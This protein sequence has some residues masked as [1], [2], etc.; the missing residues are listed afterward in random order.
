MLPLS[1]EALVSL[2]I[3][4]RLFSQ[5]KSLLWS[6]ESILFVMGF[7][8]TLISLPKLSFPRNKQCRI[9]KSEKEGKEEKCKR[10]LGTDRVQLS[11]RKLN[12]FIKDGA[13]LLLLFQKTEILILRS[14]QSSLVPVPKVKRIL[15]GSLKQ[16]PRNCIPNLRYAV[17]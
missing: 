15:G 1:V 5:S 4:L 16:R 2:L 9:G 14:A 17:R 8:S 3:S 7:R 12:V 6:P 11:L 13:H 10:G